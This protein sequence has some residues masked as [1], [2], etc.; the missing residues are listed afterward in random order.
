MTAK[1]AMTEPFYALDTFEPQRSIGYLIKR[2]T[3]T[4]TSE[5]D[6]RFV[7]REL[8]M[9][10]W[11]A[12]AML[13]HNLVDNCAGLARQIGHNSGATTRLIDQLEARGLVERE[14]EHE[15]RR[16][17]SL[18]VTE[19]GR[20]QLEAMTPLVLGVWNDALDG[21]EKAE[22][23]TLISLLSRLVVALEAREA[24]AERVSA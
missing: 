21:F 23:V 15:D 14:R 2:I 13:R 9:T 8:N 20:E 19:A 4:S 6:R 16:I 7:G 12:L 1:A 3:K 24:A 17:V 11:I 5:I 18:A 10:H 22:V